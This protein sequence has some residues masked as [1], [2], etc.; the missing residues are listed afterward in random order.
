M[1]KLTI[2]SLVLCG[3]AAVACKKDEAAATGGATGVADCDEYIKRYPV[4]IS[5]MPE[6]ARPTAEAGFKAQ[7]DAWK[8]MA[9]TPD[10]KSTLKTMCKPTLESLN[11]NPLCK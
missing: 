2:A 6:A 1:N 7:V 3:L 10:G 5:K 4:C 11:N 9:S 8:T